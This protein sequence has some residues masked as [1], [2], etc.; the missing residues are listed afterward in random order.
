MIN[1]IKQYASKAKNYVK[2]AVV[3]VTTLAMLYS[4]ASGVT[5]SAGNDKIPE[6]LV[7]GKK[8]QVIMD[9]HSDLGREAADDL[10]KS[11]SNADFI[12]ISKM[13]KSFRQTMRNFK[14]EF[15]RMLGRDY[16]KVKKN[17]IFNVVADQYGN[18]HLEGYQNAPAQ[19]AAPTPAPAPKPAA[20]PVPAAEKAQ[21]GRSKSS[22]T[23][24]GKE[25]NKQTRANEAPDLL[26]SNLYLTVEDM[27]NSN[28]PYATS[29][30]NKWIKEFGRDTT[31][32]VLYD[33]LVAHVANDTADVFEENIN[34]E[35]GRALEKIAKE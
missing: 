2:K 30:A 27:L 13:N 25:E 16:N 8:Y 26:K 18:G 10:Y 35:Q 29:L 1:R 7:P 24:A 32:S 34:P 17:E 22:M 19:A 12:K 20:K 4:P 11:N 9:D 21:E 28:N 14:S 3:T 23:E 31:A 33:G 5:M 6:K 15:K